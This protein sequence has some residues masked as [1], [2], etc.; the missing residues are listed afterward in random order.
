MRQA[1]LINAPII[2][3]EADRLA[4]DGIIVQRGTL[5][6]SI[7]AVFL[8]LSLDD[9]SDFVLAPLLQK[10]APKN[11]FTAILSDDVQWTRHKNNGLE[12]FVLIA[13][14]E[15]GRIRIEI[16]VVQMP[17]LPIDKPGP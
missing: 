2:A 7:P 8:T 1:T 3:R 13:P 17:V 9:F 11:I 14:E 5:E 16:S 10:L 4:A 12:T 6:A 15:N